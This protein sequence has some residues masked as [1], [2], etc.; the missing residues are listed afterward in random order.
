M[1][2]R[3]DR[4]VVLGRMEGIAYRLDV[5]E[6]Q[7]SFTGPSARVTY[8]TADPTGSVMARGPDD[9]DLTP[10][11]IMDCLRRAILDT[12]QPNFVNSLYVTERDAS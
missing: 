12:P 5:V 11:L 2:R 3:G 8:A 6:E 7:M 1:E 10:A 9:V 4:D